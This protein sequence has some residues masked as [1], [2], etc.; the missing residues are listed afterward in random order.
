MKVYVVVG[1]IG[2]S[3]IGLYF[4]VQQSIR[5]QHESTKQ[6]KEIKELTQLGF[7]EKDEAIAFLRK[8]IIRMQQTLKD[9]QQF[10]LT[11]ER[12][13]IA[14]NRL[15][16]NHQ[17]VA[18]LIQLNKKLM[19]SYARDIIDYEKLKV[20]G[21]NRIVQFARDKLSRLLV[22]LA[23]LERQK[24]EF[25]PLQT[26]TLG[27]R[28]RRMIEINNQAIT[29]YKYALRTCRIQGIDIDD[30][31]VQFIKQQLTTKLKIG[32]ALEQL[33]VS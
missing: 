15:E 18:Q 28:I 8:R 5:M 4:Y 23:D 2:M 9:M 20:P 26:S 30:M 33:L 21:T 17:K 16:K 13:K 29:Y 1:L 14:L 7:S 27:Q 6:F 25:S 11:F 32:N 3:F 24:N 19:K 31:R 22:T 12:Q 10:W